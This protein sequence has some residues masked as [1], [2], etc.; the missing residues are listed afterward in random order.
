M[1]FSGI[2]EYVENGFRRCPTRLFEGLVLRGSERTKE[3]MAEFVS[4]NTAPHEITIR[5]CR[6]YLDRTG[7]LSG[8]SGLCEDG[9]FRLVSVTLRMT[10][11]KVSRRTRRGNV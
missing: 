10:G 5:D 3:V 4:G 11:D 1:R 7:L 8:L 9:G 2:R 6:D